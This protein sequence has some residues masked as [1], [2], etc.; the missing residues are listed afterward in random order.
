MG[1]EFFKSL[2]QVL[3][4]LGTR[5]GRG[6]VIINNH[7]QDG[8]DIRRQIEI[9]GPYF[10][11][12][13]LSEITGYSSTT[14]K[15][16]RPF[17]L[18]TFDDGKKINLDA[19]RE[20][21]KSGIPAV[22]Y[23]VTDFVGGDRALWFDELHALGSTSPEAVREFD[24]ETPKSLP[25]DTLRR[26]LDKATRKYPARADLNDPRKAP[27]TWDDVGAL[28]AQ[29]FVIGAHTARHSILTN[30]QPE[31]ARL[32]IERSIRKVSVM[33]GTECTTFAFP[34]G[35][36]T[37]E[38]VAYARSCGVTSMMTTEPAWVASKY[39][40]EG[41]LP[42]IQLF[43]N[44]TEA[45]MLTKLNVSRLGFVLANPDGTRRAYVKRRL[46]RSFLAN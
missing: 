27:L 22:F 23:L 44:Q 33:L 6:G 5:G 8:R 31:R 17:C 34:N 24:L 42:R 12:V 36:F 39:D 10:Q 15:G 9:L 7:T 28:A 2:N 40:L 14:Q 21:F 43:E 18:F 38:L 35:N 20:L 1:S 3:L 19:A 29:G 25:M 30:E 11:F 37:D 46:R 4:R 13:D 26:R 41:L 45:K 16:S 32:E